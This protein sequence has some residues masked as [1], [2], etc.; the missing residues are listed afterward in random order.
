[1]SP[2]LP[3]ACRDFAALQGGVLS[4]EQAILS[5][6]SRDAIDWLLRS[7][8][9][10][11]LQRGAYA[12]F[13]GEPSREGTLWAILH[14]A[15][16]GAVLSHQTAAELFKLTDEPSSLVHLTIPADRRIGGIPGAV[17]HRSRRLELARHPVLLPPRTRIEPTVLD[18]VHQAGTFERAFDWACRACQRRLTTADHLRGALDLRRNIRWRSELR[19][20]L[21]DIAEGVQSPLEDRYLNGVERAHGL[22]QA[23]RQVEVVRDRHK[24]YRDNLYETYRVCVELDGRIAH[25]DDKRWQDHRRDNIAASE[26]LVTLRFNWAD[27]TQQPCRTAWLVARALRQG[28]WPGVPRP[29][30][31]DCP[32]R[33]PHDPFAV[34]C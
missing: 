26:G 24:Y 29:C 21:A 14:R 4:R 34:E 2:E 15:G 12:V 3:P 23:A 25:P 27:V 20:A 1:M 17:V 6:L 8:R 18:L 11:R 31:P 32:F 10:Q 22:P 33:A 13:T 30:G 16:S 9:W 5:G 28:G 19:E 7:G